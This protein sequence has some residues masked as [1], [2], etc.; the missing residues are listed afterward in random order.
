MISL[1]FAVDNLI[2]RAL[3][4]SNL[5]KQGALY[6]RDVFEKDK[7]QDSLKDKANAGK[8]DNNNNK[9][10]VDS[11]PTGGAQSLRSS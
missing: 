10:S 6:K 9:A 7:E 5:S 2:G 11:K 1:V 4:E 3:A 8:E